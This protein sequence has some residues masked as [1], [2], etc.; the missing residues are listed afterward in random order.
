MAFDNLVV[1]LVTGRKSLLECLQVQCQYVL[2]VLSLAWT[3]SASVNITARRIASQNS[4]QSGSETH[5]QRFA[6]GWN[7]CDDGLD[8]RGVLLQLRF[9]REKK[10]FSTIQVLE[11]RRTGLEHYIQVCNQTINFCSESFLDSSLQ[12]HFCTLSWKFLPLP[13]RC[14]SSVVPILTFSLWSDFLPLLLSWSRS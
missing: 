6:N 5:L 7:M 11:S 13:Q 3:R 14:Q 8:F 10:T 9:W 1:T 2:I 12:Q 4:L